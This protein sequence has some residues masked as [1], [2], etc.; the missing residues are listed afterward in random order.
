MVNGGHN[1]AL[2]LCQFSQWY[3]QILFQYIICG[4]LF[5]QCLLLRA[6]FLVYRAL[7]GWL[8]SEWSLTWEWI[9]CQDQP[10]APAWSQ[11]VGWFCSNKIDLG[12][13]L[14]TPPFCLIPTLHHHFLW[15]KL[16]CQ[17]V[18]CIP[19]KDHNLIKIFFNDNAISRVALA[20]LGPIKISKSVPRILR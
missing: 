3:G 15:H 20:T 6:T 4:C 9:S 16:T 2:D 10:A 8:P 7:S 14:L 12:H 5:L 13:E 18:L 17:I 11:T 1:L 19:E